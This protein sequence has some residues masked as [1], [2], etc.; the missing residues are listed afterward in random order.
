MENDLDWASLLSSGLKELGLLE[1]EDLRVYLEL[2]KA[3]KSLTAIEISSKFPKLKRTHIYT[4]LNRLD[5]EGWIE[6]FKMGTK[7][8]QFRGLNPNVQLDKFI[9]QQDK[10]LDN[11]KKLKTL[12][13]EKVTPYL[14]S[15]KFYGGRVSNTFIIP[16][17]A[18]L[19]RQVI[20][21]VENANKRILFYISL[22]LYEELK[23]TILKSINRIF[24]RFEANNIRLRDEDRRDKFAMIVAKNGSNEPKKENFPERLRIIFDPNEL[25]TQILVI[26]DFV[27]TSNVSSGFGLSMRI[28][29]KT[30][31]ETYAILLSHIFLEKEIELL[32]QQDISLLGPRIKKSVIMN[33]L[34]SELFKENWKILL[35][36]TSSHKI[37]DEL[38][39]AAPGPERAF[40]KLCGLRYFPKKEG[41]SISNQIEE[42][43]AGSLERGKAY[44][45]RLEKQLV[46][47]GKVTQKRLSGIECHVYWMKYTLRKEWIPIIGSI[48]N[49]EKPGDKGEGPSIAVFIL[50]DEAII[51]VWA[52]NPENVVDLISILSKK[53]TNIS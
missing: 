22:E 13:D 51:C 33:N 18:E 20:E 48:P 1:G 4:I 32:G 49:I 10:R 43:F 42:A 36:H 26:D 38:G 5:R 29:D 15:D 8:I 27:F 6:S 50:N 47:S 45:E 21:Y 16:T 28:S 17:T 25:Q 39:L 52:I 11:L 53:I 35:D 14:N 19:Y 44:I 40:F 12:V 41:V 31:A 2:L 30:I 7:P 9:I 46:L 34:I 24:Q 3:K 23:K 37:A